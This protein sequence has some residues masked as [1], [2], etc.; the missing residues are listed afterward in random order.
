MRDLHLALVGSQAHD[1]SGQQ[2]SCSLVSISPFLVRM[3][4]LRV[5]ALSVLN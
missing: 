5:Q 3:T 2:M 4:K 1:C